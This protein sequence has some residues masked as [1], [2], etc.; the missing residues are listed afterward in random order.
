[1]KN[2]TLFATLF[3]FFHYN[4]QGQTWVDSVK[5]IQNDPSV[6]PSS[7]IVIIFLENIEPS[8]LTE[9]SI[10][11]WGTQ[12]GFYS[13]NV[14]Y[15]VQSRTATLAHTVDFKHGEKIYV[16]L[17]SFIKDTSSQFM[18][19]P[20]SF[21]FNVSTLATDAQFYFNENIYTGE[22]LYSIVSAFLDDDMFLDV[23][24]TNSYSNTISILINNGD[25]T[26]NVESEF[27]LPS[28]PSKISA[29][30]YDNDGDIDLSVTLHFLDI[31][32][33]LFNDG[34]G[35]FPWVFIP[36]VGAWPEMG[37][38][39]DFNGDGNIDIAVANRD[40]DELSILTNDGTGKFENAL[41]YTGGDLP[42]VVIPLDL[43]SDGDFDVSVTNHYSNS[44]ATMTNDG[45]GEFNLLQLIS[46]GN[47]PQPTISADLDS[48]G[49]ADIAVANQGSDNIQILKNDG[50]GNLSHSNLISTS[51]NPVA[52]TENDFD[53]DGDIDIAVVNYG[54]NSFSVFL[55]D[56]AANFTHH[57]TEYAGPNPSCIIAADIDNDGDCDIMLGNYNNF[58]VY[59]NSNIIPVELVSFLAE[60][61]EY[62]ILLSW[63]TATEINNQGFDIERKV[64]GDW[65][66]IG[67][68]EGNGTS[69]DPHYYS[70]TDDLSSVNG[71]TNV[72]YRL[73][74]I[75]LNGAF[76]YSN[77]VEVIISRPLNYSLKQNYP[78]P[79]NPS[80]K[81]KVEIAQS[82]YVSLKVYDMLGN[83]IRTM[84]DEEL[85]SGTYELNF[86]AKNMSSGIYY[87]ELRAN[88]FIE[89]KKMILLR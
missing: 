35:N 61:L 1:M 50:L 19:D 24:V 45:N 43:D 26:F 66:I 78:N 53:G 46:V 41:F 48:D 2:L 74:Q 83:G 18:P 68:V 44:I 42:R 3:L 31:V 32:Y 70:F 60:Q 25:G 52:I 86:E 62:G 81:I 40:S 30:D 12:N 27:Y 69:S 58:R 82:G 76:E 87:Y 67:F 49:D 38:S 9:N 56:G 54:D 29:S 13:F 79:F 6:N 10:K 34:Q 33:I 71:L 84:I 15:N 72:Y 75:D 89:V 11:I 23:A 4:I 14:N 59:L 85:Q 20:F 22:N 73:K 51:D 36:L 57:L 7:E 65:Q 64:N 37:S 39:C 63:V 5:P 21:T 8:S 88:E 80:T 77:E 16:I 55:N 17:T 28:N 47:I